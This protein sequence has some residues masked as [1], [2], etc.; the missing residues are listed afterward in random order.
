MTD[1]NVVVGILAV[2]LGLVVII[3]PLIGVSTLSDLAGI[4]II[5]LGIWLLAQSFKAWE[6]SVAAAVADLIL[7]VLAILWGVMFLG[8]IKAFAFLT[9][10]ALYIVGFFIIIS[11]LTAIFSDKS[12]KG[13]AI[14]VLGVLMGVFFLIFSVYLKNPLVLAATV[15]AFLIIAGVVEIFDLLGDKPA[16]EVTQ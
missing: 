2:I 7:A 8:N 11:G 10:I 15:G 14:G 12:L 4:G 1:R 3:F 5:F 6:T 13:K 9:F 16:P